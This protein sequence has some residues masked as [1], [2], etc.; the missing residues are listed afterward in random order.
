M[1][2]TSVNMWYY[3]GPEAVGWFL[4]VSEE[5]VRVNVWQIGLARCRIGI[6][7]Q[8]FPTS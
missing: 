2:K 8:T 6:E 4:V 7:D 3:V 1:N 5:I